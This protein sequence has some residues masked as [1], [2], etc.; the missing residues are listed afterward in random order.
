MKTLESAKPEDLE[1]CYAIIDAGRNFQ[2]EQGFVQWTE[3]YPTIDIIREDIRSRKG[4]V[5]RVENEIAGYMCIDFDGEPAYSHIEGTWNAE[6]PYAVVHRMAFEAGFRGRGLADTA[7]FM[8]EELCI[9]KG[10]RYIRVDTDFP[11][12]RMQHIFEKNGFK[13]CG[14]IFFEGKKMAFDKRL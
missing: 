11:N 3:D 12:K 9:S 14:V 2:R 10:I 6:E 5:L 13:H 4:Y 7:F 8:I 1:I